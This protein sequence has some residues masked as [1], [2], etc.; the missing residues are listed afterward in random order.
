VRLECVQRGKRPINITKNQNIKIS[1]YQNI[2]ISKY[3]NIKR[4][5]SD[6][7][8]DIN[9]IIPSWFGAHS[10]LGFQL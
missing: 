10:E 1:K 2:K 6:P 4:Q 7:T 5:L 3:Q 8:V 9:L